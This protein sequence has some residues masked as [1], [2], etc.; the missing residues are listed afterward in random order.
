MPAIKLPDIFASHMT[1]QRGKV[2]RIEGEAEGCASVRVLLDG[3]SAGASVTDG[4]FSCAVGPFDAG[5]D[6]TLE[7]FADDGKEPVLT[8]EDIQIGDI[9]LACGQSNM[10]YFLRYDAD[11]NYTKQAERNPFI[12]MYNVPQ[13]AFE[14]QDKHPFGAGYWFEEGDPGWAVFSAPGYHF[15]R[16][17]QPDI[18]VPV[19]IVGCNWGGTPACAW[20]DTSRFSQEPLNVY[21]K[22]Y[23]DALAL[24]S[25]EELK[26]ISMEALAFENSY[27][28]DLEWRTMMYGLTEEEQQQWM[29]EHAGDPMLPMGPWHH[30]RPGGLYETMIKP[31]SSLDVKGVLWYQGES[32]AG[33]GEIYDQTMEVLIQSFRDIWKDPK[34]PF[35]FVQLAPFGKWLDCTN[36]GYAQVRASQ[37]RVTESIPGTAMASIMDIGSYEDIHPKFKMEVGRRLA[38]LALSHVYGREILADAPVCEAASTQTLEDGSLVIILQAS[39]VGEEL[40]ADETPEEGFRIF[41]GPARLTPGGTVGEGPEITD[42]ECRIEEDC[43]QILLSGKEAQEALSGE[44]LTI[45]YLEEN[46]CNAHIWNSAGLSMKPFHIVLGSPLL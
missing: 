8:L 28:H 38:L 18:D 41:A 4:H 23:E 6:K 1:L 32:D 9:Y 11:W 14:G 40:Y 16:V 17:I 19:A 29:K 30:Y 39:N 46:Y 31:I 25:P 44:E 5:T 12:R 21:L 24:Y 22:E 33:H 13:I 34:L 15:A 27:R 7:V 3:K 45:S 20:T 26:R 36:D 37:D 2:L 35:L 42:F 43:I 10:E